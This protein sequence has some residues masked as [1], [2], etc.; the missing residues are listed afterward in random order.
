[1]ILLVYDIDYYH[2]AICLYELL[3]NNNQCNNINI[4]KKKI[5]KIIFLSFLIDFLF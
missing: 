4:F 2:F 1:M 3:I 5:K